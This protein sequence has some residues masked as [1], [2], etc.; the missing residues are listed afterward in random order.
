[1]NKTATRAWLAAF[2]L[3][4]LSTGCGTKTPS[5]PKTGPPYS[6][7]IEADSNSLAGASFQVDVLKLNV[8]TRPVIEKISVDDYFK[9]DSPIRNSAPVIKR[10]I[11]KA[12][13]SQTINLADPEYQSVRYPSYT[14]VALIGYPPGQVT[15]GP[16]GDPR[17][18]MLPLDPNKWPKEWPGKKNQITVTITRS[19]GWQP[20]P[21]WIN[22]G[23]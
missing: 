22:S 3:I 12:G 21:G 8:Q 17:I 16:N 2:A 1:M 4:V 14:D 19:L 13:E 20:D 9:L 18:I 10:L 23:P 15:A 6:Y 11:L 5:R 7:V